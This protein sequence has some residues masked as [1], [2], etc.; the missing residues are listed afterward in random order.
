[1]KDSKKFILSLKKDNFVNN[2][3][4]SYEILYISPDYLDVY[5]K[6]NLFN[7]K[8]VFIFETTTSKINYVGQSM[9]ISDL[10]FNLGDFDEKLLL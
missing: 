4:Y 6:Y 1:M 8:K 7:D 3:M 9:R 5:K 2:M 10:Y